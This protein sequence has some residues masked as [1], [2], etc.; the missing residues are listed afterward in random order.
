MK[1]LPALALSMMMTSR[2]GASTEASDAAVSPD[3]PTDVMRV[4]P[5]CAMDP[6]VEP[7]AVGLTQSG[8]TNGVRLSL[9]SMSPVT[10]VTDN[11]Q[12]TVTLT[13][14]AGA[15]LDFAIF[16][17]VPWMPDHG[18]GASIVPSVTGMGNGVYAVANV[19]LFM[20]GVWTVTFH[21]ALANG[22]DDTVVFTV[23]IGD[24]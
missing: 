18:H 23:C 5:A 6:R 3:V 7:Y 2:C 21:M 19:D 4:P 22:T 17:V 8:S 15:P 20:A 16:T 11:Y 9:A 13:D 14:F 1:I 10:D 12:W 24:G